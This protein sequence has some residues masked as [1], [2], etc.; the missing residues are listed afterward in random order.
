MADDQ[1]LSTQDVKDL[2]DIA[3]KLPTGHP[4]QKKLA[5]LL[6]S[7]PTQFEGKGGRLPSEIGSQ[8]K[9]NDTQ[10][11]AY[12]NAYQKEQERGGLVMT[13]ADIATL[14]LGGANIGRQIAKQGI[15]AAIRPAAKSIIGAAAGSA[16]GSYGGRGIGAMVGHPEEGAQ[17]GATLGG[18]AGGFYG[19]IR[20][21]VPEEG[22]FVP[23]YKSPGP[24][25][26]P[27]SVEAIQPEL[28]SPE[29]PGLFSK[30]PSRLPQNL[31]RDPFSAPAPP[32]QWETPSHTDVLG[33][34]EFP[35]P[36]SE[37]PN[38]ISSTRRGDPFAPPASPAWEPPA[39]TEFPLGSPEYPGPF[40]KIPS[41][42][43]AAMQR[44]PFAPRVSPL[45]PTATEVEGTSRSNAASNP[46]D[47][48]SRMKKIAVPGE[49][50]SAADLK[51]AGDFTQTPLSKLK[52][53]A[54]FGDKLA[55]NEINRRLRQ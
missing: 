35:G 28:G 12:R 42:V 22:P 9:F 30:L 11:A 15:K 3:S 2:Q 37:I 40:S 36:F 46:Q 43:P 16:A 49:E 25:R 1:N 13:D 52:T 19:G 18:L 38:R 53:L 32:P 44:D 17:I 10:E 41:R 26:G 54:K 20:E 51:R 21:P 45:D 7:Q 4:M 6:S 39:H 48:I 5:L 47:L 33:S 34:P 29:N 23:A 24:Y 8:E 50:P 14:G 31:R 55:Q 27:K